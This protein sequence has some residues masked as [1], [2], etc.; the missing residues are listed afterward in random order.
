MEI[1]YKKQPLQVNSLSLY[2]SPT[3]KQPSF[4]K[5]GKKGIREQNQNQGIKRSHIVCWKWYICGYSVAAP[6]LPLMETQA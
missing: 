5:R 6:L 1:K 3:L 4:Y 2:T